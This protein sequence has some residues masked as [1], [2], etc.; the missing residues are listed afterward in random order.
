M[1]VIW[2]PAIEEAT[3][4]GLEMGQV[5]REVAKLEVSQR[6]VEKSLSPVA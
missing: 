2:A 5:S 1:S 6:G 4:L 3:K